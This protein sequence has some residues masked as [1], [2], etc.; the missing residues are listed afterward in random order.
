MLSTARPSKLR[1]VVT[2]VLLVAAILLLRSKETDLARGDGLGLGA[3][4]H[5]EIGP[6][7]LRHAGVV[8]AGPGSIAIT[9]S[10]GNVDVRTHAPD[11]AAACQRRPCQ[12][13]QMEDGEV[14][15][16]VVSCLMND[17]TCW[18]S[19]RL[20]LAVNNGAGAVCLRET[21]LLQHATKAGKN[22]LAGRF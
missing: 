10:A 6:E 19:V 16:T 20:A 4:L 5:K 9:S 21:T 22:K 11:W 14:H 15:A 2:S 13:A 7:E 17:K 8:P 1:R 3:P 18:W 12:F